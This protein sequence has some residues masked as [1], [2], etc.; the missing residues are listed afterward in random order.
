MLNN[1]EFSQCQI[2]VP[3][4]SELDKINSQDSFTADILYSLYYSG[5]YN[6]SD[7]VGTYNQT[8]RTGQVIMTHALY[9]DNQDVRKHQIRF[10]SGC[11]I[12]SQQKLISR[13]PQIPFDLP[14]LTRTFR[15]LEVANALLEKP[16]LVALDVIENAD[17]PGSLIGFRVAH[18]IEFELQGKV[19]APVMI[20]NTYARFLL[21]QALV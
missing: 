16:A 6:W 4:L 20:G 11:D 7:L 18:P 8:P 1:R 9:K 15:S 10:K 14:L 13:L 19:D 2:V 17:Q 21:S 3:T 12:E 5:N